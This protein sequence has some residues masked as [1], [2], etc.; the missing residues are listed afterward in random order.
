MLQTQCSIPSQ[1]HSH[2]SG[3]GVEEEEEEEEEDLEASFA[4]LRDSARVRVRGGDRIAEFTS[5]DTP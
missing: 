1:S 2:Q 4:P 5:N 3:D